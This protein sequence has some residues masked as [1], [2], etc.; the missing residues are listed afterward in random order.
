MKID[1][2]GG[3]NILKKLI[4]VIVL[5][6]VIFVYDCPEFSLRFVIRELYLAGIKL[7]LFPNT[8]PFRAS[9]P[10]SLLREPL[11]KLRGD[12][13]SAWSWAILAR[14]RRMFIASRIW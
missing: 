9:E 7:G 6:V 8:P 5:N 14:P 11:K 1:E 2:T 3:Q 4:C 10:S 13:C 12:K